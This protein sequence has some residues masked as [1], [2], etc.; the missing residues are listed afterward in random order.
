MPGRRQG[1]HLEFV[2][3][4]SVRP[5]RR[6]R[7]GPV[8]HG[9]G[10][11]SRDTRVHQRPAT[12]CSRPAKASTPCAARRYVI[13]SLRLEFLL[14]YGTCMRRLSLLIGLLGIAFAIAYA[15]TG[16][17]MTGEVGDP[18]GRVG[19]VRHHR[20]DENRAPGAAG[21]ARRLHPCRGTSHADDRGRRQRGVAEHL[22]AFRS[23]PARSGTSND[24][25]Q[26]R[27]RKC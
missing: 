24:V 13:A 15:Q 10:W 27:N 19:G 21:G 17:N 16:G 23:H 11:R 1:P 4:F 2:W 6:L 25:A 5:G 7:V 14:G 18:Q 3:F 9:E 26:K 12:R 20:E 8:P 22:Y